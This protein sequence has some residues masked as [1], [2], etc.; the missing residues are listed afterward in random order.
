MITRTPDAQFIV[1]RYRGNILVAGGDNG[2][3]F[4]HAPAIGEVLARQAQGSTV[5]LETAFIDPRRFAH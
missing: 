3:A 5:E 4:K 1:G 2:H